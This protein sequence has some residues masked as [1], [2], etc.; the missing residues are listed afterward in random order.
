MYPHPHSTL[1][2]T[3]RC[4]ESA[5]YYW[6]AL[7]PAPSAPLL[8]LQQFLTKILRLETGTIMDSKPVQR[9]ALGRS[10]RELSNA[11]FLANFGFDTADNEPQRFRVKCFC[12]HLS[13]RTAPVPSVFEDSPVFPLETR[14]LPFPFVFGC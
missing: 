12:F 8:T 5:S 11:Y 6:G 2:S 7:S 13:F 3:S 10:R 4:G 9:S 14:R 1:N